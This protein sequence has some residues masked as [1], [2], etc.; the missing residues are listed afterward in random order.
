MVA[1]LKERR[2]IGSCGRRCQKRQGDV[3]DANDQVQQE[4][5]TLEGQ[6]WNLLSFISSVAQCQTLC[7]HDDGAEA[8]PLDLEVEAL[9]HVVVLYDVEGS[10][11]P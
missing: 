9:L 4:E 8:E 3:G 11:H 7:S 10:R 1:D 2:R 5:A 6:L